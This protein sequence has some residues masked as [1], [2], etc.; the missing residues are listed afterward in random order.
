MVATGTAPDIAYIPDAMI[1]KWAS[2]GGVMD[3]SDHFQ[4]NSEASAR[5]RQVYYKLQDKIMG[6]N[7]AIEAIILYYSWF[8]FST[9]HD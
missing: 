8:G 7:A 6:T 2:A 5:M 4:N 3:L 1:S 9:G